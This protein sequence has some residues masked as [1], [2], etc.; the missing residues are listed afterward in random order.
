VTTQV[1]LKQVLQQIE[2]ET[3]RLAKNCHRIQ[4]FQTRVITIHEA[5][6]YARINTHIDA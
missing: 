1:E 6:H 4:T 5:T 2:H 3:A